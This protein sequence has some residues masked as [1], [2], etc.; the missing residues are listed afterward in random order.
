MTLNS[1]DLMEPHVTQRQFY[2][3]VEYPHAIIIRVSV[4]HGKHHWLPS[5]VQVMKPTAY[6]YESV[7]LFVLQGHWIQDWGVGCG[8]QKDNNSTAKSTKDNEGTTHTLHNNEWQD[9]RRSQH[10]CHCL[11]V[12]TIQATLPTNCRNASVYVLSGGKLPPVI[13]SK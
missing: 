5:K 9:E 1:V 13:P 11:R 10:Q 6:Y 8:P 3:I 4:T 12:H 2:L 7:T